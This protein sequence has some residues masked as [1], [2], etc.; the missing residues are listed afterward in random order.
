[1]TTLYV[2]TEG[3][4]VRVSDERLTV[5]KDRERLAE[6]PL[7]KLAAVVVSNS[8]A[9]TPA[10]IN[11]LASRRIDLCFTDYGGRFTARLQPPDSAHVRLRRA[12][13]RALDDESA[14][15]KLARAFVLGKLANQR[16]TTLRA[17]RAEPDESPR[18]ERL[19]AAAA[20]IRTAIAGAQTAA[21]LDALRGHE[22]EGAAAYFAVFN[23]LLLNPEFHFAKRTRQPPA[24]PINAM[25]SFGYAILA[26]DVISAVQIVGLDP[27]AGYLHGERYNQPSLALDV[28]EEFRSVIVDA[29]VLSLVNR[30]QVS[31]DGFTVQLGGAILMNDAT[32]K[33]FLRAYEERK[34]TEIAHPHLGETTTYGRAIEI[35]ARV[36]AKVL[37]GELDLYV[38][39][40]LK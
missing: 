22:G 9:V 33:T 2:T 10:A 8:V 31:P 18:R 17:R 16:A 3:A 21:T 6:L 14:K 38:P 11:A 24:D 36:V 12:Q 40:I 7:H 15:L 35:Q 19:S 26:K 4:T 25:L 37:L 28:M 1:M 34:R 32:R 13:Y 5:T 30:R 20:K 27:F 23:D 39:F 29:V